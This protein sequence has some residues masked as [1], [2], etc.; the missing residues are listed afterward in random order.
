[1]KIEILELAKDNG[2]SG[3][4]SRTG[5]T[6]SIII[7]RVFHQHSLLYHIHLVC[8]ITDPCIIRDTFPIEN[9]KRYPKCLKLLFFFGIWSLLNFY[10]KF[11]VKRTSPP[12]KGARTRLRQRY[13]KA[14]RKM[15]RDVTVE[16]SHSRVRLSLVPPHCNLRSLSMDYSHLFSR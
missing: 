16:I 3:S 12:P 4:Q 8:L 11:S 10:E 5:F 9:N 7:S 15:K 2:E 1:M 14:V 6:S 13:D